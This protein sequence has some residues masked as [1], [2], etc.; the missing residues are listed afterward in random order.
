M[1]PI[2]AYRIHNDDRGYRAGIESLSRDE[3]TT[4]DTRIAVAFSS[5]NYKDALA[6]TG[7]GRILRQFPLNG[8]IDCAGHIIESADPDLKTGDAVLVTGSGLSET[9][10]GGYSSEVRIDHRHVIRLPEGWGPREAM[11][12]GTAGFTAGLALLRMQENR[13]HPDLGPIAVTGAT[14]GVGMLAT[15]LFHR[16]GYRVHAVS[17]KP[18]HAGLLRQLGAEAVLTRESVITDKP[19]DKARFG[20]AL[21]NVGGQTLASLLAQTVPY[22]N[23]ASCGLVSGQDL[24]ATVMPFI[25]RGVS[26]LG[27][28]SAGTERS[29]RERVWQLLA[30]HFD[31]ESLAALPVRE[32]ALQGLPEVFAQML[33]GRSF[34]RVVVRID[35]DAC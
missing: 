18:E 24:P 21:D 34:G 1:S 4:G 25:I 14:G 29:I 32:T 2:H 19:M 31:A 8:G 5:V 30:R 33:S 11:I 9:V 23:V 26:L 3:L 27:I 13:Q 7:Q 10:D 20:G 15:A 35:G 16:A 12:L 22:G 28:A 6:G 17:G